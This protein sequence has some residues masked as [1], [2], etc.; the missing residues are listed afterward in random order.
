MTKLKIIIGSPYNVHRVS[1]LSED[2]EWKGEDTL[3]Q[4]TIGERLGRGGFAQV[5]VATHV[6]TQTKLA[7]KIFSSSYQIDGIGSE[8][9]ILRECRH[10]NVISYFGYVSHNHKLYVMMELCCTLPWVVWR[11]MTKHKS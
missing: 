3:R 7:V 11:S 10:D 9:S 2:L 5:H 1:Y 4:F 8:I 6:P